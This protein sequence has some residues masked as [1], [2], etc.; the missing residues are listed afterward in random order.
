VS[1]GA[2]SGAGSTG[3]PSGAG[4]TG[5]ASGAGPAAAPVRAG[6]A[7]LARL[8]FRDS[9][10]A[11]QL[12]AAPALPAP[13]VATD[14]G[15]HAPGLGLWH[16][17]RDSPVDADA[18][19]VVTAL[20]R[21]AD[22][23]LAVATLA[24]LVEA[25]EAAHA[26]GGGDLLARLRESRLLRE[27][28]LAVLGAS[29]A[30]GE[31]L[32][33][34]PEDWQLLES[35]AY[36][37]A[38]DRPDYLRLLLDAVGVP[39]GATPPEG[40]E[41]G[42]AESGG[43]QTAARLR[44]A[45]RRALLPLAARDLAGGLPVDGVA[46]ELADL[47]AATL[48]A[49]LAVA[50]AG[51]PADA[52][53]CRLAVVGMGKAGGRELNYVSDVDVVFV[54]EPLANGQDKADVEG[55]LRT[56]AALAAGLMRVCA[57]VAWPVD[58]A[59]RPEGR[60]GPLVRTLAS[61][62]AYYRRWAR[63]WEF[64]ALL[65][66]RPLAGDPA[67]GR[68]YVEALTPLVW[69]AAGREHFVD[70]VQS[71][72]RR[73]ELSVG[74]RQAG[75]DLK[76]GP[77]GLRDVE[78]A[79]QLLQLV[80]GR[81]DDS[82]RSGSTLVALDAL[83]AGGYV[84][85]DDAA[86]L[87]ASYRFLRS[88]EHRLML[89]RLR[90][91]HLLPDDP[92]GLRWV[93]RALGYRP[94]VR[95]DAADV[96]AA[97]LALHTREVRRLHEKLFYRPLL[98][99]VARLPAEQTRLS[100]AAAGA[101]L[102]ALGFADPAGAL[103]HLEAL[104]A[105]VSRRA[106][107]Q[108]ALLPVLLGTFADAPDPDAGLL[109]Y[110][111]VSDAL[112]TS[113]WYL[114]LLRDEGQVADRLARLLG[115]SRYVADLLA[116]APEALRMLADDAALQPR[117]HAALEAAVLAAVGRREDWEGAAVVARGLRRQELLRVACADLLGLLGVARVGPALSDVASA[118]LAAGLVAA[119]R[120]V[121]AE[122]GT[123]LPVRFAV[124][125][126]GRLGG[127]ELGYGSDADVL[128]VF[129]QLPGT[130]ERAASVAAHRVAEELR[131]LL[132]LPAPDPPLLVDAGLRPEG[133]QGPLVRSL[134]SYA[135]YYARWASVWEAQALLRAVPVAGDADL[136][137]RF[138]ALIDPVRYPAAGL[139]PADLVEIRRIKARVEAER[140]P[141]GADPSTHTKLG[142][143]GLSDVEW[144]AQL[145]QLSHAAQVPALRTARTLDALVAARDAGLLDTADAAALIEAWELA[146]AARNAVM[147]VRGRAA[148]SLPRTGR[149][150][151]AVAAA[152]RAGT[153][154]YAAA[155]D[156]GRFLD[157]YRRTTR[158]ARA[159]V[160]RVFYA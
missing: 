4:S 12:L 99:A 127:A 92:E 89:Q 109:A 141:R 110:R 22:P 62:E 38:P 159:V 68:R 155:R 2:P 158:R 39:P 5:A 97:E 94:D 101:R 7:R 121:E 77:G 148:D 150:L 115:T 133:R 11:A 32:V 73:V 72:R 129:E 142:R 90:R 128:F 24:R 143:G 44:L 8:G 93:A 63:T 114:G 160:E 57:A 95:G 147:L 46:A 36:G 25:A 136:G 130:E 138:V 33:A 88:L 86:R 35:T 104:T 145:L 69:T 9:G 34:S 79:V 61:H 19:A 125:A 56:A 50:A 80:H 157:D 75:R 152:V 58:A 123:A 119:V 26:R 48:S 49:A 13:P 53:A 117:P 106:S 113:P 21:A 23:D 20:S 42:R 140:L 27:R 66:A 87:A 126:M 122:T 153:P 84:G 29:A 14:C 76:L 132:A 41:G 51:L 3:A 54:A 47:A 151:A 98:H 149:E 37:D 10:R 131:R 102:T 103:R 81:A 71:M 135:A 144:T 59:L 116:R 65:K 15:G 100:P 70:E 146:T 6:S 96:F 40:S 16:P 108:R 156:P 154:G 52:V 91:T 85:R 55:A 105:G 78:F 118:T 18:A 43:P 1:T 64:Q 111:R 107:I 120:E 124:I 17:G 112:Q 28:L 67:L 134:S 60:A 82:L 137:R 83:A 30:L 139:T 45:Y 31:H 74:P